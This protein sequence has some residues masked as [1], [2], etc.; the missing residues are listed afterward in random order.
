MINHIVM[1]SLKGDDNERKDYACRFREAVMALPEKI[2]GIK[3]IDVYLNENP[4]ESYDLMIH[5]CF[6]T[7]EELVSY[8]LH[9]AHL[10]AVSI[11]KNVIASRACIDY[12]T[13]ND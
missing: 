3:L 5:A 6:D 1:F 2:P 11:I 13:E 8:S 10:D 7:H 9:P 4:C 12:T